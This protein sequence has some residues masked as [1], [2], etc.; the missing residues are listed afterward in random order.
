[1][2]FSNFPSNIKTQILAVSPLPVSGLDGVAS[3]S[4]TSAGATAPAVAEGG[5]IATGSNTSTA[6]AGGGGVGGGVMGTSSAVAADTSQ[7][8][9]SQAALNPGARSGVAILALAGILLLVA[10]VLGAHRYYR[11]RQVDAEYIAAHHDLKLRQKEEDD[12]A[13]SQIDRTGSI[14][15]DEY[16]VFNGLS[17]GSVDG[18]EIVKGGAPRPPAKLIAPRTV[19]RGAIKATPDDEPQIKH[20]SCCGCFQCE[21]YRF[22]GMNCS[23]TEETASPATA[24]PT[25]ASEAGP[26]PSHSA[27]CGC[28][29]CES[30]RCCGMPIEMPTCNPWSSSTPKRV[31]KSTVPDTVDV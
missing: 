19:P 28:M 13:N 12:E 3:I 4:V 20:P 16:S 29:Q 6:A 14:D 8:T 26:E 22:C 9:S 23:S 18:F 5:G 24:T 10:M 15:P 30:Y 25:G 11:N 21:S 27:C 2:L 17:E 7:R 1:M 31:G